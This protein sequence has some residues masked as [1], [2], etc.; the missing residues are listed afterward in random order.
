MTSSESRFI[1]IISLRNYPG[2]DYLCDGVCVAVTS[3]LQKKFTAA[4]ESIEMEV[5]QSNTDRTSNLEGK[6]L[7]SWSQQATESVTLALYR[8]SVQKSLIKLV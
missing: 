1:I 5:I 7:I 8:K 6:L 2:I 3:F 4:I